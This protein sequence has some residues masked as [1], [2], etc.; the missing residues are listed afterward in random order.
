MKHRKTIC[1]G[2]L[3]AAVLLLITG[4]LAPTV[5]FILN[6]SALA[7]AG[8]SL[9]VWLTGPFESRWMKRLAKTVWI[10]AGVLIIIG[11]VS[12]IWIESLIF[13][14]RDGSPV[15]DADILVV[16]GAGL[17]GR[18]PSRVLKAR[19]DV[20]YDYMTAHPDAVAVLTGS[21]GSNEEVTEA[22]AMAQYLTGKGI[23]E[24]RLYL[25]EEAHNTAQNIKFSVALMEKLGLEGKVMVVSSDFHL[26]RAERIFERFGIDVGSLPAP[27]PQEG[28]VPLNCYVRE[29][30]SIVVMGLKDKIGYDE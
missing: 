27:T 30:C 17:N 28:L 7:C 5:S 10:F 15:D 19:L 22:S 29:Y 20:T 23:D 12:F 6:L 26:Y 2:L 1:V 4:A 13:G 25:E 11:L 14:G 18:Q 24:D 21:Q 16:L 8:I 3:L 9:L